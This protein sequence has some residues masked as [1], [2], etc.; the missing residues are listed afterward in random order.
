M[1]ALCQAIL[2]L[3]SGACFPAGGFSLRVCCL[4]LFAQWTR[5]WGP[6]GPWA[7]PSVQLGLLPD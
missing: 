5:V 3:G 1:L 4:S 6:L 7:R 2:I